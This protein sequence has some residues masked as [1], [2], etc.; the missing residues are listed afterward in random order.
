MNNVIPH[1]EINTRN[2]YT[3]T[4]TLHMYN[5]S[6]EC[7]IVLTKGP[8]RISEVRTVSDL[9]FMNRVGVEMLKKI[10]Q[11]QFA[12]A[13]SKSGDDLSVITAFSEKI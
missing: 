2:R 1:K 10:L 13:N 11:Q 5:I 3:H 7:L 8:S 12:K 9:S 6:S 4:H